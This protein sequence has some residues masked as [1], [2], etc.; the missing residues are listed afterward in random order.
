MHGDPIHGDLDIRRYIDNDL[1]GIAH[2]VSTTVREC[3]GHLLPRYDFEH[4]ANWKDS[5]VALHAGKIV[6]V[7]LTAGKWVEDLWI[8]SNNRNAGLGSRLLQIAEREILARGQRTAELRVVAENKRAIAFYRRHGWSE[9]RRY[10]H[11]INCFDMVDMS[12]Q[13]ETR[14]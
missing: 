11:E 6:G 3:Y 7:V 14:Y 2:V 13:L 9:D 8:L 10:P 1:D 5:W 4:D 12:K